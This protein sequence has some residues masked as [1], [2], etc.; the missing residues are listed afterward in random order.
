MKD[1]LEALLDE[2]LPLAKF[3]ERALGRRSRCRAGAQVLYAAP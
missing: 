2:L 1:G 3:W